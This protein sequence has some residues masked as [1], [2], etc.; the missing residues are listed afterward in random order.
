[1][2][3]NKLERLK[4]ELEP[5]KFDIRVC[6]FNN[7]NEEQRFY[8]KNYGI[9]NS[10]LSPLKFMLRIRVDGGRVELNKLKELIALAKSRN[11]DMIITAR[12]GLEL[13]NIGAK[14]ILDIY[15]TVHKIGFTTHQSLTDNIRAIVLE[16]YDGISKDSLVDCTLILEEIKKEFLDNPKYF[17]K[18]P[19]KFNTAIISLTT[20]LINYWGNDVLF[21]LAKKD[22]DIG[23]NIYLG[24]KN[25]EVAQSADIFIKP[26]ELRRAF[27]AIVDTFL[28]EGLRATR[29]KTRL[30]YLI[31]E[32]G[33]KALRE[34][35]EK[36][37]N[38]PLEKEQTLIMQTSSYREFTQLKDGTFAKVVRCKYGKV[39]LDRLNNIIDSAKEIRLGADQNIHLLGVKESKESKEGSIIACAGAKY[40]ALSLWDI[41]DDVKKLN[42]QQFLKEGIN[43]GFSGCLKGCGRHH[44]NHIGLVGLRSNM[45]GETQKALRVFIGATELPKPSPARLLYYAV[46]LYAIDNLFKVIINEYKIGK[47]KDFNEFNYH[48]LEFDIQILQLWFIIRQLTTVDNK[49][50]E[51]FHSKNSSQKLLEALKNLDIFPKKDEL[52]ENITIL[53]HKLWDK[54]G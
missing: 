9:Y 25:S 13:H 23:F 36:R 50:V 32:I 34:H 49:T 2:K 48:L 27:F 33:I 53:S 16:P 26:N 8:L 52:Y 39:E 17:G 42:L 7:L 11:L 28:E 22:N 47:Y 40:C 21:A 46:P 37:F 24:G 12:A 20:P 15:T 35:I 19:R 6:D 45:F 4:K 38:A 14:D 18:L 30:F 1:M 29:S 3:L 51:L 44:H 10:K 54:E 43:I 31:E 41:K 5:F